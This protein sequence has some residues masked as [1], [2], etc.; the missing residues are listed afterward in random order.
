MARHT[1]VAQF[2]DYGAAHRAFC[3][4]LT[5]GVKPQDISLIAGDRSNS[6]GAG[7]DFGI[8]ADDADFHIAAVRRGISLLA[9]RADVFSGERVAGIIAAH[10]PRPSEDDETEAVGAEHRWRH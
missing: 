5:S 9:V 8:L 7:R 10:A 3:E 1:I 6:R 2:N 4:L